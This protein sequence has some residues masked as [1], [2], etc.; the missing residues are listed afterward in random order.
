MLRT[1]QPKKLHRKR[2]STASEREC[3][4]PTVEKYWLE[5]ELKVEKVV[6]LKNRPLYYSGLSLLFAALLLCLGGLIL[7]TVL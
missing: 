1:Y 4:Q 2:R 7:V 5:E 3:L 6:L